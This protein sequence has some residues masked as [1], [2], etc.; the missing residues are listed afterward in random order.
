VKEREFAKRHNGCRSKTCVLRVRAK[1][2]AK[3][4]RA[5]TPYRCSFGRS[6]IPCA[7]V[8]CESHGMWTALNPSGAA[9]RYQLMPVHNRPWPVT[10]RQARLAHHRIAFRLY[11]AS[12]AGPW[13]SSRRC[14]G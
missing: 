12:G 8:M 3:D 10:T 7:I 4:I 9:G 1:R 2:F 6:A 14:W 11:R 5:V 13:V